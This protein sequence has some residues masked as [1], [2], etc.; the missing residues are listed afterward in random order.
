MRTFSFKSVIFVC[1]LILTT[2][3][4]NSQT[5]T[6]V[7][8]N[9]ESGS[10][11]IKLPEYNNRELQGYFINGT[12]AGE[13]K[14]YNSDGSLFYTGSVK[15]FLPDGKGKI[16]SGNHLWREGIFKNGSLIRGTSYDDT[17]MAIA[18]GEFEPGDF[19]KLK[20]GF[21]T[22]SFRSNVIFPSLGT[23]KSRVFC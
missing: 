13:T 23:F 7:S 21:R 6:C 3:T 18:S 9:C 19:L 15:D 1:L 10:G 11:R 20:S 4:L 14:I 8:G 17:G 2:S 5:K 22:L 12:P 16:F